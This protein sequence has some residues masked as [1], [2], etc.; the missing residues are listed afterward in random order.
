MLFRAYRI[1]SCGT[2]QRDKA[3]VGGGEVSALGE[4]ALAH[5][6][7]RVDK[8]HV[9]DY[10]WWVIETFADRHTEDLFRTGQSKRL[11]P[12]IVQRARSLLRAMLTM[13]RLRTITEEGDQ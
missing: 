9:T 10:A 1:T 6:R 7:L 5:E 4:D 8:R 12:A 11:P 3:P 2:N 13:L